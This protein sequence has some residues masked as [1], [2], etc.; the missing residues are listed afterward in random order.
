MDCNHRWR[1]EDMTCW[2]CIKC[3]ATKR[4]YANGIIRCFDA[5]GNRIPTDGDV[6]MKTIR[7]IE[8]EVDELKKTGGF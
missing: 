3:G 2:V 6:S 1:I 7:Q 4:K 8:S 5:D